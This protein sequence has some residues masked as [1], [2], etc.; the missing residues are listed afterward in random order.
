MRE[1]L[2]DLPH[3]LALHLELTL[4]ALLVGVALSVPL[5]IISAK[6]RVLGPLL[7]GLAGVAQTIPSL[8]LLALMVPCLAAL[9]APSIGF[10]PAFVALVVYSVL[11][12]LRNTV[13]GFTNID[14]ALLEA[15]RGVGMS[16]RQTLYYVELPT[17]LPMIAAGV[18]TAA[19]WTVGAA[20]LAT[21]VGAQSL[22]NYIFTGLQ[23][24]N[25]SLVL[26][27][28]FSA[29][30]LS[31]VLDGLARLLL[32]G[33]ERPRGAAFGAG[34][35]ALG[36]LYGCAGLTAID[37]LR[38]GSSGQVIV[39]TK[40]F[41]E[42]YILAE[43]LA[44]YLRAAGKSVQV[45]PSLGSS[46]LFDGLSAGTID[47]GVD[48]SGTIWANVLKRD[49]AP[50]SRDAGLNEIRSALSNRY[51]VVLVAPLGFDNTYA[52]AVRRNVTAT[53]ALKSL[54]DLAAHSR[55]L[56]IGAD[57]EFFA[58]PEWKA[59]RSRYGLVFR[60]QRSMDPSLVYQAA[61][62]GQVDVV[63]AFSTDG[64]LAAFDLVVLE[65][66]LQVMPR[67][68]A[69]LLASGKFARKNPSVL[70]ALAGLAGSL[71]VPHMRAMNKAVDQEGRT[72]AV[73]AAPLLQ[74]WLARAAN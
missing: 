41:T 37:Q 42:Q 40:T 46:V 65:D 70:K 44:G 51:G 7:L 20:T 55:D 10:L 50:A 31:L 60:E 34:I 64:R 56:V 36:A 15:A 74:S 19:V 66:N 4:F 21:P 71:D 24:R 38:Q 35:V 29:A 1:G 25:V 3:F 28:C 14:P 63:C 13:T 26:I 8:A 68:D 49:D 32:L 16:P 12:V 61:S 62:S 59:L 5:G 73:A 45:A 11:P 54:S 53:F 58:R 69:I 52:I 48:Y 39:G 22:G 33:V 47:L 43:A 23:T 72:P 27:G 18:R 17:A 6:S 57:Y 2:D 67:Y 30:L 9:G